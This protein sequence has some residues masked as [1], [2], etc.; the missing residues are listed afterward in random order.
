V[1]PRP[2][3]TAA[4]DGFPE[5]DAPRRLNAGPVR[6]AGRRRAR[7]VAK[8][9][10]SEID[11]LP[12]RKAH[13]YALDKLEI[14][15]QYCSAFGT[16]CHLK[17]PRFN[18]VDAFSG[19]GVNRIE[20]TGELVEGSPLIALRSEPPF[21]KC[22]FMDLGRSTIKTLGERSKPFG[23]RAVV[24]RG[25]C[26]T[27]LVPAMARILNRHQP[28]LCLLDPEGAEL[29]WSAVEAISRF[30][31]G[32]HKVEQ[33]ILLATHTGWLRMLTID[34]RAPTH[35]RKKMTALYGTDE[36]VEI[37]NDRATGRIT[38]DDATTR[39]VRLY[40]DRLRGLGYQTL[41]REIRT[42][43]EEGSLKYFLIFASSHDKGV[44]IMDHIF[45]HVRQTR[46]E[47]VQLELF[48]PPRRK[49]GG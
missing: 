9:P 33:L 43:G 44:K 11:G 28:T 29:Q 21:S 49:R 48:R 34:G 10:P 36:W 17:A 26:N 13:V 14:V 12:V 32:P 35:A 39:Y 24:E 40:A 8:E 46:D 19:P 38:T 6:A 22:L 18:F 23:A 42:R 41:D 30:R 1:I 15:R 16:A 2:I 20:E 7:A 5:A 47:E 27:D 45:D 4:G 31:P 37:Y 3:S 25:D